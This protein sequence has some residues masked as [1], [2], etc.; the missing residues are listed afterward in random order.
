MITPL[1]KIIFTQMA[2]AYVIYLK[3]K[4]KYAYEHVDLFEFVEIY[5][6]TTLCLVACQGLD[7]YFLIPQKPCQIVTHFTDEKTEV[8]RE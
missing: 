1:D 8:E 4:D 3:N 5:K 2:C 7:L 6:V